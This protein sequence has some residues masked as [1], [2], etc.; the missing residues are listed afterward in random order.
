MLTSE[1][2]A[3]ERR[4]DYETLGNFLGV[5]DFARESPERTS[6]IIQRLLEILK[7]YESRKAES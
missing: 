5:A 1:Q 3:A 6:Q 4:L 2:I 7:D